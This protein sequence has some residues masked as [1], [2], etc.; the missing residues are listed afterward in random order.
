MTALSALLTT[1]VEDSVF[2]HHH[3]HHHHHL[4]FPFVDFD[5][6]TERGRD[7]EPTEA[8][9]VVGTRLGSSACTTYWGDQQSGNDRKTAIIGKSF[10]LCNAQNPLGTFSHNF[11]VDEEVANLLRIVF[12]CF[13]YWWPRTW[14]W[15]QIISSSV[16]PYTLS[17][18]TPPQT[19]TK[20]IA[21]LPQ[22]S[23]TH[24]TLPHIEFS[25]YNSTQLN[26]T[27]FVPNREK[28]TENTM[29]NEWLEQD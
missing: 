11:T 2:R 10:V 20:K 27:L 28:Q 5:C 19:K 9:N 6:S 4:L 1:F 23:R 24:Y 16:R 15:Y 12:R 14:C 21:V 29:R 8:C 17:A 26:S 18:P 13:S 3:H 22:K 7:T 25:L